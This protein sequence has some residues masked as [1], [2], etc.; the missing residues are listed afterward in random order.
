MTDAEKAYQEVKKR[1]LK[2]AET[3]E[4]KQMRVRASYKHLVK[5]KNMT[6]LQFEA[7][8]EECHAD[9]LE[10]GLPLTEVEKYLDYVEK[11]GPT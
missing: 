1:L 9:L 3:S 8:W 5:T 11:M 10:A 7:A 4:E 6:A 2:F